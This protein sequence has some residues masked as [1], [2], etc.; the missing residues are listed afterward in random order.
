MTDERRAYLNKW[1]KFRQ[2]T[3]KKSTELYGE[4]NAQNLKQHQDYMKKAEKEWIKDN[5]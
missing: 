5:K 4:L 2:E 1:E 3:F